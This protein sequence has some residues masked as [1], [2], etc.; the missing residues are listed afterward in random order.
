[1]IGALGGAVPALAQ[2][3]DTPLEEVV[4][5]GSRIARSDYVANSPLVTVDAESLD[6]QAG[7]TI[8][9]KLQQ[10]PQFTPGSNEVTGS[11]QPT[12]RAS[13]DL[14]GLGPN[15]TLVLL[16]GK[17][18]QPSDAELVVDLNAIPSALIN[19]VE[20]ITGGASAVYGSDAVAGVV[21]LK[22]RHDVDGLELHSRHSLADEGDA[23]EANIGALIGGDFADGRGYSITALDYLHRGSAYFRSREFYR[24]A[25]DRGLPPYGQADLPYGNFVA[26]GT[27]LPQQSVVDQVFAQYGVAPGTVKPGDTLS[28]ND[29][30]TLFRPTGVVNYRGALNDDF[31]ITPDNN[32]VRNIGADQLLVAPTQRFSAFN[33]TEY[34]L[35]EDITVYGQALAT[36]YDAYTNFGAAI[37][38]GGWSAAVPIDNPF[39]PDDLRTI[40]QSRTDPD[41]P[42]TLHKLW[43]VNGPVEN[44]LRNQVLQFSAGLNG[45]FGDSGWTW[46]IYGSYGTTDISTTVTHGGVSVSRVQALL[47]SR[48]VVGAD[49]E[50]VHVPQFIEPNGANSLVLN[51]DYA[52]AVNDGG[53]T[54]ASPEGGA[55][56]CP[57]GLDLFGDE[58]ISE[59]CRDYLMVQPTSRTSLTQKIV[60]GNVQ[61]GLF[62]L[63]AGEV[64][65]VA[66]FHF[67]QNGYSSTPSVATTGQ[68]SDV[69][70]VFP[71]LPTSGSTRVKEGYV[72]ALVPILADKPLVE[73]LEM[74][75]AYRYSD[76]DNS[77]GVSTYKAD[78]NW[79]T[80]GGISL[81]GG[82]ARAIRAPNVNELF[83]T[84]S[85][86]TGLI[87]Y[88]PCN[89]DSPDRTGANAEAVRDMCIAQGVPESLVDDYKFTFVGAP[90]IVSG[91]PDV[92]PEKADSY[93]VG[94]VWE[95]RADNPLFRQMSV[96]L[97]YYDIKVSDAISTVSAAVS[98][99]KCFNLDGSNPD[100]D[101]DNAYCMNIVRDASGAPD[102]ISSPYFNLG[103]LKTS[104]VD[105]Q[106]DWAV[107]AADLGLGNG[108]GRFALNLVGN[109]LRDFQIQS[110]PGSPWQEYGHTIGYTGVG[111]KGAHPRWKTTT[112]LSYDDSW[113]TVG[114]RWYRVNK[115]ADYT[116]VTTPDSPEPGVG[117]YNRFDLF[118]GWNM[119]DSVRLSGGVSNVFDRDPEPLQGRWG[120]TDSGTYDGVGRRF[121]MALTARL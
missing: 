89:F 42:L 101:P 65:G 50:L 114:L 31:V 40:L 61:G 82:Y 37:Q 68:T 75:V 21:N 26:T 25:F 66:G 64:R 102:T 84:P 8:G 119:T 57:D 43:T 1:M 72:E 79:S 76:Y 54:V 35:T 24:K 41:A 17:R 30:G 2:A 77:G 96:S 67:R 98:F 69:L 56:P 39:I 12:G 100:L 110:T 51:P 86:T 13:V 28:F 63:P 48:S 87:A 49:G 20:I 36:R 88:D 106:F 111:N 83:R 18:M 121:Y 116:I 60:E 94:V 99:S 27:N 16:D 109:Y 4:V 113:G 104:G 120:Q 112:T 80:G 22:L 95:F 85:A 58:P 117:S 9:L 15:R 19:N 32:L 78:F 45:K 55:N 34:N 81:R 10:M 93:T 62:D 38:N 44:R 108:G 23:E 118:G 97:D 71:S 52:T 70:G 105:F 29:D 73:R 5:T 92:K 59:S 46:D 11:G 90:Q 107:Q 53:V 6:T 74:D 7:A 103:G 91:N 115:M 14:R 47:N 33:R 3:Q